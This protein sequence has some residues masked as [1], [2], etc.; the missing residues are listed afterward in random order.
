MIPI[1]AVVL[2]VLTACGSTP[3]ASLEETSITPAADVDPEEGAQATEAALPADTNWLTVE[4]KT[5]GDLAFL[6]NPDAPVTI[7]DYSDFL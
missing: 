2:L 4:G 1:L 6:G 3:A 7:I 5:D